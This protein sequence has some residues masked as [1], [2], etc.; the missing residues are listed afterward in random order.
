MHDYSNVNG[1]NLKFFLVKLSLN[2]TT[3]M[4]VNSATGRSRCGIM[5]CISTVGLKKLGVTVY[6]YHSDPQI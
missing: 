4:A 1:K 3:I 2:A 5:T 6:I